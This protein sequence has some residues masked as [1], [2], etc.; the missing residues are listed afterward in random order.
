MATAAWS[1][2]PDASR[3]AP[4]SR[5]LQPFGFSGNVACLRGGG[6]GGTMR[7]SVTLGGTEAWRRSGY[8]AHSALRK[9]SNTGSPGGSL[10]RN[11]GVSRRAGGALD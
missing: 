3:M 10:Q 1:P 5:D 8:S 9:F 7:L 4:P 11:V 6:G 2:A